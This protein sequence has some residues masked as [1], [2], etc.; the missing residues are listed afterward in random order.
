MATDA[1]L[2]FA[3]D[4]GDI[5]TNP[6][7]T[8]LLAQSPPDEAAEIYKKLRSNTGLRD[9]APAARESTNALPV[10]QLSVLTSRFDVTR[11]PLSMLNQM[12]RDP[13]IGFALFFIRAQ[14]L[15]ARW[16]IECSD[17][18]VA[19]FI[20]GALRE[21]WPSLVQ[22]YM[23]K[24]VYGFAV[25][26]KRFQAV[27]TLD[28]TYIDP[29]NATNPEQPVWNEGAIDAV[30]WK[31]FV[32]LPPETVEPKWNKDG[33]FDGIVYKP[34]LSANPNAGMARTGTDTEFDV[35]HSLWFTNEKESVHGSLWGYPRIGYAYR[36]WWSFWFNWGLADRH[37]EKDADPP[38]IVRYPSNKPDLL[39]NGQ[40]VSRRQMALTIGDRARSNST[41][42]MPSDPVIDPTDGSVKNMR[43]WDIEFPT[44]KTENFGAFKDRFDQLINFMF[45]ALM[46]PPEA[47]E[48]KGGTAGY[49]STGQQMEAFAASQVVLMQEL[50]FDVNRYVI[51]QLVA[52]N[53]PER[54]V[55]ARKVTKGF[56]VE[57][58]ELAKVLLQGKANSAANDLNIDWDAVL[59]ASG[60]PKLSPAAI[61]QKNAEVVNNV[62]QIKPEPAKPTATTSGVTENG[63]YYGPRETI[64]LS[65]AEYDREQAFLAELTEIGALAD[66]MVMMDARRLRTVWQEAL[67][68]DFGVAATLLQDYGK[69]L[70]LDESFF[71]RF[72]RRVKSRAVDTASTTRRALQSI[73]RRASTTEF[74]KA[75]LTDFSW[76]PVNS[77]RAS[78]Y[79]S[80]RAAEMVNGITETTRQ[81]IRT[82]LSDLVRRDVPTEQM[83]LLLRAHFSMFSEWRA[84]QIVRTEVGRAY[85]MAVLLA[86]QDAGIKQ[87][88]AI[89]AQ[90][91]PERSD[92]HCIRRNGKIFTIEQAF[93]EQD[94]EHPNGTLQWR[95]VRRPVKL[96]IT[97][98]P[99]GENDFLA[100]FD[101]DEGEIFMSEALN[102]RQQSMYLIACIDQLNDEMKL[103]APQP[104]EVGDRVAEVQSDLVLGP[105]VGRVMTVYGREPDGVIVH[106]VRWDDVTESEAVPGSQLRLIQAK[107]AA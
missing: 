26:V 94:E 81:E 28:W 67:A 53:F 1:D 19:G 98:P 39:V 40:P 95:I 101:L 36:F 16:M 4:T 9:T 76:D 52:A 71:E 31:P 51:P 32:G 96:T 43:E 21:I 89:D 48:A 47:F 84:D 22:Q 90:L 69:D 58:V 68:F 42:A 46:V 104:I 78:K 107:I 27:P 92:P 80:E 10:S 13:V 82:F 23:M 3:D 44:G 62:A 8:M 105:R 66:P 6:F 54:Q 18:Q 24:L 65:S 33:E 86:A 45:R 85:N 100:S 93:K 57:D 17:P 61:A 91:G 14:H 88:Q 70:D 64:K 7:V 56:D 11:I 15:R 102:E 12:M 87:V 74:E 97:P 41:I 55:R 99:Q 75:G 34:A 29:N 77:E 25:L 59:D 35:L 103:D 60:I 37:F 38:A 83:P 20:D 73:M 63:L 72:M 49:N 30:I 79:L 50:D 5:L 106:D 2:F